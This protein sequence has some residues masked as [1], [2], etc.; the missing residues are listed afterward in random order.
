MV[1]SA[2]AILGCRARNW[3]EPRYRG[4]KAQGPDGEQQVCW[5]NKSRQNTSEQRRVERGSG[6]TEPGLES[7]PVLGYWALSLTFLICT[8][9]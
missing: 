7:T 5:K 4:R 6:G 2:K 8:G 9:E 3:Y 1:K